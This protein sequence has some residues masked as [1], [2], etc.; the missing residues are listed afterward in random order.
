MISLYVCPCF[1]ILS[2]IH[3]KQML[4]V[5]K[6]RL[7]FRAALMAALFLAGTPF[8]FAQ[9]MIT[10]RV[11]DAKGEGLVGATIAV[12]GT[13]RGT[14]TDLNGNF[15]IDAPGSA[16]TLNITYTG[17]KTARVQVSASSP[18][19]EITLEEDFAGLD[20]VIISGLAT[21][22]K[23]AN[24]ANSVATISARELT[25]ITNQSTMDGALYGKFRGAEIRANSGAPGGGFSVRL[26]GVTSIFGN[27]QPLYIVDGVFVNNDAISLGT[28]IVSAAAGGGNPST[29]QDDASNRIADIDPED[30]ETIEILKGASAAAIYGSRAAGGVVIITTKRGKAGQTRVTLN[31]SVGFSQPI[32]LLGMRNWT[33]DLVGQEFG[34]A[35][36]QLFEQNGLTDYEKE[37]YDNRPLLTATRLDVSGGNDKTA[38]FIGG[39]YRDEGGLVDNTGYQKISGR[40]NIS[41]RFN[42][43]IDVQITNNYINSR[44]DRG[45]FNN[46]N[47]NTTI[48]YAHAFTK[49]WLNLKPATPGGDYPA[50]PSVGSNILETVALVTNREQVNRYIGGANLNVRLWYNDNNELKAV[51]RA[52]LD[53]FTLHT[54]SIFPQNLSYF[55][56]PGTLGGVSIAGRTLNTNTNLWGFLVYTHVTNGGTTLRT[57]GGLTAENFD[58]NVIINTASRLNGSQTNLDQSGVVSVF[59]RRFPQKDRGFFLQQDFNWKDRIMLSVGIR[60]DKSTNNGDADKLYYYPKA[61]AAVNLHEFGDFLRSGP[62]S[63]A[64]LRVAYGQAGRFSNF[65]DRFNPMVATFIGGN[66]GLYTA[67]LRG[68]TNVAPERQSELEFGTDLGFFKNRIVVDITYYIKRI[69]DLLLRAQIPQSTGY[70][71]QVINAGGLENRGI[72]IGLDLVP[73]RT[74]NFNWTSSIS[75][76]KNRSEVTRLDVP[77]FNIGGFALSLG[78]YRIEK[79]LPATT[80]VGT[81][82]VNDPE[83]GKA[84][85][86]I[87]GDAEPDFNMAFNNAFNLGRFELNFLI[88]WRQGG[89]AINLSTLLWDLGRLTWDYDDKTLDP[90]GQLGNGPYRVQQWN[91]NRNTQPWIEDAGFLRLREIGLYYNIPRRVFS[92]KLSLRLGVSGRNVFNRFN[93]NSYDPEVSNFGNNVLANTVE[94]TPFPSSKRWVFHLTANF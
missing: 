3:T 35:D 66:N 89:D 44:A 70:T 57:Q 27:Q 90:S 31:Q 65:D 15:R 11:A 93:Y 77:A 32:R 73:I 50:V 36:R 87:Y 30:I 64:K 74:S 71:T 76:W 83:F 61:N 81:V 68:N 20:E 47:T 34:A 29:N 9:F 75:F 23:R 52:G 79:G 41:H 86:K 42:D 55:R 21:S 13:N 85:Y 24:L 45:F 14:T 59:Q 69:D 33:A 25:G 5:M 51:V 37:L 54:T 26:R 84:S 56:D 58:Q 53:Q 7:L 12:V 8:A 78:Q 80:I 6:Y 94:V 88:H 10:G 1:L 72:E 62:V 48:G 4:Y 67:T 2:S 19:V 28:N 40:V 91:A 60:G 92:D 38:F 22:V 17:Y 63:Q 18:Q 39:T 46:S 82:P 16:A 49:P 43:W